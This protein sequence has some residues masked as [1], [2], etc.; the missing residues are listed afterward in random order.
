MT[1]EEDKINKLN[2]MKE[3]GNY[4]SLLREYHLLSDTVEEEISPECK[5]AAF[6]LLLENIEPIDKILKDKDSAFSAK[7]NAIEFLKDVDNERS[8]SILADCL[9][10]EES[11]DILSQ[12]KGALVGSKRLEEIRGFFYNVT[13]KIS[14]K[15]YKL[16]AEIISC[17]DKPFIIKTVLHKL[18]P[19]CPIGHDDCAE[20]IIPMNS[21]FVGHKFTKEKI[22]DM[23]PHI[24]N[25]VKYYDNKC[26]P[27]YADSD[28]HGDF[29]CKIC[30]KIQEARFGIYDISYDIS[31]ADEKCCSPNPN[32]MLEIGMSLGFGKKTVIIMK[33]GQNLPS[34]LSR[35]DII[36]YATYH[37]LEEKLKKKVQQVLDGTRKSSM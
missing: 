34:D 32:V 13:P 29:F 20:D 6:R 8:I 18:K 35:S 4:T 5:N 15:R 28:M 23:R 2:T 9:I 11:D 12:I 3:A 7:E 36:F 21:F 22:D 27:Y 1:S 14:G 33:E 26:L 19:R 10:L 24:D 30:K 37:S 16:L 25:A 17:I 31:D